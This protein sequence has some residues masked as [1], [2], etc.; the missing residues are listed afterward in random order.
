MPGVSYR[1]IPGSSGRLE[2]TPDA[3]GR[4]PWPAK[5]KATVP[6]PC[7]DVPPVNPHQPSTS[8]TDTILKWFPAGGTALTAGV[9]LSAHAVLHVPPWTSAVLAVSLLRP[10]AV[11]AALGM[12]FGVLTATYGIV[13]IPLKR[14]DPSSYFTNA[15]TGITNA[16]GFPVTPADARTAEHPLSAPAPEPAVTPEPAVGSLS[17]L[18]P[19]TNAAR[20]VEEHMY[21]QLVHDRM[22][23]SV[24]PKPRG[25]HRRLETSTEE[26]LDHAEEQLTRAESSF[27]AIE[28]QSPAPEEELAWAA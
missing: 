5:L 25:R 22:P 13:Y 4:R 9:V 2:D 24:P 27:A 26:Y 1:R 20:R 8:T 21:W 19:A 10:K 23:V 18:P 14:T 28:G 6:H 17:V 12:L 7:K 3:R 15:L 16:L 11:V